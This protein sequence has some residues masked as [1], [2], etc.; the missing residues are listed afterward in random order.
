LSQRE[1]VC[2]TLAVYIAQKVLNELNSRDVRDAIKVSRLLKEK[3]KD[4]VDRIIL[5]LSRQK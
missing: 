3:T 4:E 2:E 5:I 1:G